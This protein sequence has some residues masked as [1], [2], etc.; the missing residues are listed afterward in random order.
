[1]SSTGLFE[2]YLEKMENLNVYRG[3]YNSK[4]MYYYC[5]SITV[6]WCLVFNLI[7]LSQRITV[8]VVLPSDKG[9]IY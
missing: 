2:K 7:F 6:K 9:L 8:T 3:K 5:L 4:R 1:M